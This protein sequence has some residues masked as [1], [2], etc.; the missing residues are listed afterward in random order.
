MMFRFWVWIV[1][2]LADDD[3]RPAALVDRPQHAADDLL[4]DP[5][6]RA[7]WVGSV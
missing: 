1:V 5:A 4:D 3:R 6:G 2:T 7:A